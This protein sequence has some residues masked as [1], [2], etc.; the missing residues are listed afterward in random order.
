MPFSTPEG[1]QNVHQLMEDED[2]NTY[3]VCPYGVYKT[4][5]QSATW[6][7][8]FKYGFANNMV[9]IADNILVNGVLGLHKT[10]DYGKTWN[11]IAIKDWNIMNENDTEISLSS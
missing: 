9:K 1:T 8:I 6:E 4:P 5:D 3:I 10:E 11:K 7:R 2:G